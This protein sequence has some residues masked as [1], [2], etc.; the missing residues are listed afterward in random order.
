MP[1][2][3][4]YAPPAAV[5]WACVRL[6]KRAGRPPS[7]AGRARTMR[8][9]GPFAAITRRRLRHP[10]ARAMNEHEDAGKAKGTFLSWGLFYREV[11]TRWAIALWYQEGAPFGRAGYYARWHVW[12]IAIV[13]RL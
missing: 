7:Q 2:G 6:H 9:C 13:A 4:M 1:N 8:I 11:Y 10:V 12:A 3:G 5:G